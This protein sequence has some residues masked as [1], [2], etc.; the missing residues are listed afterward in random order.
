[1]S[2]EPLA[3]QYGTSANL[4][5]RIAL[6]Q[7]CSTNAYGLQRWVFDRLQLAGGR[8]VLEIACGTGSLWRENAERL[9]ARLDLVLSDL[10]LSMIET[11]RVTV[12]P[13][14]FVACALPELPF[15]DGSFDLV[16]ANHMLYHVDDRQRGL[17]EIRRV[18][19][20]GG[21][22]FASTNGAEHLL[23]IK[24]L[25]REFAIEG[26]DISSSFTLENAEEQLRPVF[27]SVERDDYLDSLRI[28][29]A[30]LL[31]GYVASMN[32]RAAEVVAE[33]RQEMQRTIEERIAREGA[34]EVRKSTGA[35]VALRS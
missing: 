7:R 4:A 1:M 23:E 12:P 25:M 20:R 2:H 8:R 14:C 28:T 15:A 29:D 22:L 11:T 5:A 6:H 13:A 10:S 33:R 3:V 9:P 17:G 21:T 32:A 19:R 27:G 34:F 35:F 30:D 26:G 18:L 16:I 24:Q 31:L